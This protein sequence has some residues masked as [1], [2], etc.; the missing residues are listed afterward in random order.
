MISNHE[1]IQ[2]FYFLISCVFF[3]PSLDIV[4]LLANLGH[5][6]INMLIIMLIINGDFECINIKK[7][8]TSF[9]IKF[10]VPLTIV[11]LITL[12]VSYFCLSKYFYK[13]M[14]LM[15]Q[16]LYIKI[17]PIALMNDVTS[18]NND[19]INLENN[20]VIQNVAS[21]SSIGIKKIPNIFY[22]FSVLLIL[23]S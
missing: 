16:H 13:K 15:M 23:H 5:V 8:T 9:T 2:S 14:V 3:C 6:I 4:A 12:L 10:A 21:N 22:I 20:C 18:V 19:L 11:M 7:F 1:S 17:N